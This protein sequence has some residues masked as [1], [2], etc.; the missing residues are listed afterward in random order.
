MGSIIT[1]PTETD[2]RQ[3]TNILQSVDWE[4]AIKALAILLIGFILVKTILHFSRR[5]LTKSQVPATVHSILI[6]LVR[7]VLDTV[8]V[9][10]AASA[11]GIPI[12]S[13]IALLSLAGLAVSLALQG[14]LNNMASGFIVLGSHPFEVG[15]VIE[16]DGVTGTVRE[17]RVLHTRVETFDGKMVYIPNSAIAG[18]KVINYSEIGKRRVEISVSASYD[19]SPEQVRKAMEEAV[20]RTEGVLPDPAPNIFLDSY[21]DSAINY[22]IWVWANM[23]DFLKVKF[24]LTEQLYSCFAEN[25]VEM[26]YPHMNVHIKEK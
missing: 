20:R 26:T 15:D 19:N 6:M 12:T 24:Q 11:I 21:G 25:Q 22:G 9:L 2:I 13:F 8:V 7:I 23:N 10:S 14:I 5:I 17:I 16:H 3:Y 1:T 18:G 4:T